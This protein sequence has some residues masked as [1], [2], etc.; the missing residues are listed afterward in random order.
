VASYIGI[1]FWLDGQNYLIL[2]VA[3]YTLIFGG[4]IYNRV[5][6]DYDSRELVKSNVNTIIL[7]A[8]STFLFALSLVIGGLYL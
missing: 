2:A 7:S 1:F 6:K 8:T 5:V 4:I 3:A